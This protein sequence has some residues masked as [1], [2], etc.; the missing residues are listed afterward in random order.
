[1]KNEAAEVS[2]QEK[3]VGVEKAPIHKLRKYQ[4]AR[5]DEALLLGSKI[6]RVQ[7]AALRM[8]P[9]M[10]RKLVDRTGILFMHELYFNLIISIYFTYL[11]MDCSEIQASFGA[12]NSGTKGVRLAYLR[13]GRFS[14]RSWQGMQM[15]HYP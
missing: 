3:M 5:L 4:E 7:Q 2:D 15:V 1:M 12:M 14:E 8:A 11:L 13:P 10:T 9:A 6:V